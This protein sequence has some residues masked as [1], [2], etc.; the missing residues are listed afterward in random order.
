MVSTCSWDGCGCSCRHGTGPGG[1]TPDPPGSTTWA[2]DGG[3]LP[4]RGGRANTGRRREGAGMSAVWLRARAQLRGRAQAT[5]L[6]LL[7]VGITGGVVLAAV[8]GARRSDAAL[9]RFLAFSQTTDATGSEAIAASYGAALG[10]AA[11]LK[12]STRKQASARPTSSCAGDSVRD[13]HWPCTGPSPMELRAVEHHESPWKT[14][15]QWPSMEDRRSWSFTVF[16]RA[17]RSLRTPIAAR[18]LPRRCR[19]PTFGTTS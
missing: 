19:H 18:L 11:G 2:W 15:G 1:L 12:H 6:L 13:L 16:G 9:P 5:V 7:L 14:P 4:R 17:P 8:A 3:H 10:V